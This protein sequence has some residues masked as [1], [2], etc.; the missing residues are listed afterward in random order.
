MPGTYHYPFECA[1]PPNLPT[2][3]DGTHGYIRYMVHVEHDAKSHG[4]DEWFGTPFTVTKAND[5]SLDPKLLVRFFFIFHKFLDFILTSII[6]LQQPVVAKEVRSLGRWFYF[7]K[8]D[9][10]DITAN[11]T[12]GGYLPGQ[13]INVDIITY[14]KSNSDVSQ[15]KVALI[16]VRK[17]WA[18]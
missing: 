6:L 7:W 3:F 5:L 13:I 10:I 12:V 17:Y 15:F 2:S 4:F 8:S 1:L 16:K 14:N 11:L 9:A 18:Y